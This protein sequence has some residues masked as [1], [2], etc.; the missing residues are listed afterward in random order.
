MTATERLTSE[1]PA[2]LTKPLIARKVGTL[3]AS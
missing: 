2:V 1:R 3:A